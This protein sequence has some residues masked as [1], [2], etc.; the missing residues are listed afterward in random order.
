MN[1]QNIITYSVAIIA[2]GIV[3]WLLYSMTIRVE[4]KLAFIIDSVELSQRE[5]LTV[6]KNSDISFNRVPHDFLTITQQGDRFSWVVN[7]E[8]NDSLQYY[9]INNDNP[10]RHDIL[11]STDQVISLSL[12]SSNGDT[13][14]FE[15]TG[16]D[17]WNTWKKFSK[18]QDVLAR[19]FATFYHFDQGNISREDSLLWL[20]QMQ[21][22]AV[23]S[24]FEN[25]GDK[26][27]MVILD[28]N[29][30]IKYADG[31]TEDYCREGEVGTDVSKAHCCKVQFFDVSDH[32][33][34][35]PEP[36]DGYFQ[37]DGV[38]YVM[39]TS[40]KL[41]E[42]GAGHV[43]VKST[44]NKLTLHYPRPI[45]IVATVDTLREKSRASSGLITLKQN[46]NSFPTKND[47]YLPTFS[48][49]IN[50]DLCNL[51][52]NFDNDTVKVRDN[53]FK[54]TAIHDNAFSLKALSSAFIPTLAKIDL[55][56]GNDVLKCRVGYIT[57]HFIHSYLFLP[58][59]VLIVLI[60]LVWWPWSP[61]RSPLCPIDGNIYNPEQLRHYRLFLTLLLLACLAYCICKSLIALKLSY[62]FP[63]FEKMTGIIPASTSLMMILFFSLAMVLNINFIKQ[64]PI[65]NFINLGVCTLLFV[66]IWYGFFNL[67]DPAINQGLKDSYFESEITILSNPREWL[68]KV[69]IND[70]HRSVVYSLIFVEILMLVLWLLLS[71][72]KIVK[73]FLIS[74]PGL[75][76]LWKMVEAKKNHN[77]ST[78]FQSFTDKLQGV[79]GKAARLLTILFRVVLIIVTWVI[80]FL[81]CWR[82]N[83]SH[84]WS[85]SIGGKIVLVLLVAALAALFSSFFFS[86]VYDAF[87]KTLKVLF[88]WHFL[89][90]I[91]LVVMGQVLGNF[92]TA[93]I[94]L[95]VIFGLSRALSDV[96]KTVNSSSGS[97]VVVPRHC[98]LCQ[99]FM[100]TLFY[101][102]GAMGGD[103][104]YLT[105][106]LGFFLCVFVFFFI[107]ERPDEYETNENEEESRRE[108]LWIPILMG[109]LA[110]YIVA[111]PLLCSILFSP[112]KVDYSRMSRRLMLYSNFD[113][114]QKSG[115]RY[116]ESDA[117]FMVIMSHYMQQQQTQDPLSN[118]THFMH[119]SVSSGQSPVALNDLSVPIAFF[120][121][122][123]IKATTVVYFLLLTA[124]LVLVLTYSLGYADDFSTKLTHAMQWRLLA[125]F[126][127]V[128]TSLYIY[129]SYIDWLPFTGRLNPGFGVDA[130]GEALE[131]AFLLAFMAAV[132]YKEEE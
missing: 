15:C 27:V 128:G 10:N 121:S 6:G 83:W 60:C 20:N 5:S 85:L 102:V 115:Y 19:H 17:V 90:L 31:K 93:F 131:T 124:L 104:G 88:P 74:I 51:E 13:I 64:K 99:M 80:V 53:N 77:L 9:K 44:N 30:T 46:N 26:I 122:Y 103:N 42:W 96:V 95:L 22:H 126:M 11:N 108:R 34:K 24:F 107:V 84:L 82:I 118:D 71:L 100:V 65:A 40:V 21:Q 28:K 89:L 25:K 116:C 78:S 14:P 48:N 92:G 43:M 127:W 113:D 8:Y 111:L 38:N 41:T 4:K 129:F 54:T 132:T 91:V 75:S 125:L 94:T 59:G 86:F 23:R 58:L 105:N 12:F 69:G 47:L 32:C 18:Q 49:A 56:S 61:K 36:E 67:I 117:E 29:T 57:Q 110:T 7:S 79:Q 55:H 109:V 33:Y 76:S 72:W 2:L 97:N 16:A 70:T 50:F 114:L 81:I 52:L 87:C 68:E 106:Y 45:T 130:V 1:R 98:V 35:E 39:K 73:E 101:I 112:E 120:G 3:A 62:T 37:I 123:G 66:A 63:Y 119:A